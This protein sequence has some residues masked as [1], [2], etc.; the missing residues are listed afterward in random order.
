VAIILGYMA[1]NDIRRRPGE[2]S[3]EGIA[4]AGIV[5]GWIAVGLSVLGILL[6]GGLTACGVCGALGSGG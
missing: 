5:L 4:M 6:F 2:V 3:G 1:R